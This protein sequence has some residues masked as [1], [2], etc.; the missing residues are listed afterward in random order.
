MSLSQG[1]SSNLFVDGPSLA[2]HDA[3]HRHQ[4]HRHLPLL[5][6]GRLA[7]RL[8]VRPRRHAADLRDAGATGGAAKRISFGEGRYSTPVWSPR[9]DYIAFTKQ[10]GGTFA[11]GIMKPD[12]SGERILTEGFHNEGP[13][14]APE[15]PLPDVLPR[16][17]R[18]LRRADV[19]GRHHR[20]RRGAGADAVLRVRPGLVAAAELSAVGGAGRRSASETPLQGTVSGAW[21]QRPGPLAAPR[22]SPG[23]SGVPCWTT[24]T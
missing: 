17:G 5:L 3:A 14:W 18:Q 7:D 16:C 11:I 20:T 10:K 12:G 24:T 6:A 21:L 1:S 23:L 4:R 15:R 22:I 19:H 2:H 13:T 9:G 8:R